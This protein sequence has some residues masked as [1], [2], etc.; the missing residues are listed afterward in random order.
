MH[1]V[2]GFG[3]NADFLNQFGANVKEQIKF[4]VSA[5]AFMTNV[6]SRAGTW[7]NPQTGEEMEFDRPR[8]SD[9]IYFPRN[10]KCYMITFVQNKE[11]FFALGELFTYELT[12]ELFK[13]SGEKFETGIPELDDIY[14]LST[15]IVDS[16]IKTDDGNILTTDDGDSIVDA[17]KIEEIDPGA[18]N[19]FFQEQ[20]ESFVD[21]SEIDPFTNGTV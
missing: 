14:K 4:T 20:A 10:G 1:P 6:G 15:N 13:F 7:K 17:F 19:D 5:R 2:T 11:R 18:Q 3:D 9:L 21:F 16:A 8:E 12:C